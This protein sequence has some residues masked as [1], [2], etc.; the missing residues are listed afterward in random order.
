MGSFLSGIISDNYGSKK[1]ILLNVKL[2]ILGIF[3][4]TYFLYIGSYYFLIYMAAFIWGLLDSA[5]ANH[6]YHMLGTEYD[7]LSAAY[8][9]YNLI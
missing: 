3:T 2:L 9:I 4:S 8:S 5:I 7:G 6:S 1:G